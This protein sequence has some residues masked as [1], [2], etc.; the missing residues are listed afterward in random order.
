MASAHEIG[1]FGRVKPGFLNDEVIP[2]VDG[3]FRRFN[4]QPVSNFNWTDQEREMHDRVYR[5]LIARHVKDWAF[6]YEQILEVASAV[7]TQPA[8]DD[9]YYRWLT[10]ERYASSRVRY[11]TIA[12]DVGADLLTLPTTFASI[13]AVMIVDDQRAMAASQ[14]TG[15]E[16]EM[17]ARMRERRA[18]NS[19]YVDRFVGALRYRYASYSYALDHFLVETPHA[20][21]VRV[22]ERLS[23]MAIWVDYA[24]AGEFCLDDDGRLGRGD[25][26][27]PGRVLLGPPDEGEFRK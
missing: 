14:L 27:L 10:R 21:A 8:H 26:A 16:R 7:S 12:D 25:E 24:E 13:C 22:D 4:K 11:N 19:L 15:I 23:E 20:E 3:A 5:F 18:E 9:L 17:I 2:E 1:D 6:D